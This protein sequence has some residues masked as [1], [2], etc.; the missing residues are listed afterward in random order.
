LTAFNDEEKPDFNND[1][2]TTFFSKLGKTT[3]I[4]K[5]VETVLLSK[6]ERTREC[7]RALF[8][9]HCINNSIDFEGA[10][11][12]LNAEILEKH[13]KDGKRLEQ[14]YIYQKY[15]PEV[16]KESAEVRASEMLKTFFN[17]LKNAMKE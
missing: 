4:R 11:S 15:H 3:D 10:A 2:E 12:V 13:L 9:A 8:T 1:P 7:Y 14:Y 17:D 16:K 6:Q 5:A